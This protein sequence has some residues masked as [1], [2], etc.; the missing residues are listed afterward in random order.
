MRRHLLALT[1][2]TFLAALLAACGG[3]TSAP[4]EGPPAE[5]PGTGYQVEEK[6][7]AVLQQDMAAGRVSSERLVNIYLQRIHDL[8]ANGP[9]LHAVLSVNPVA[10]AEAKRLD[11]ERRDGH[12]RGPLHGIPTLLKDNIESR[13]PIATTAGSLALKDN[14]TGRD[15]VIVGRLREAGAVILGKTNLSEWANFR[16]THSTSG[17]SGVGGLTRNP[18][19]LDRN[20]CGSSSGSAAA[21]AANLAAVAVGTETDGSIT[22]PA[23]MNGIVGLK[24]TVGLM[25]RTHIVPISA[26]Q[27]TAGPMTRTVTDAAALL[28]VMAGGDPEDPA[29]RQAD[30]RKRDYT[31]GLSAESLLGKRLGVMKFL[32]GY[33]PS[34]DAVFKQATAQL[35]AAGATLIEIPAFDGLDQLGKDEF[36]LMTADFRTGING[37]LVTTAS[38]VTVRSLKDLIAFNVANKEREMPFFAQEL[39]EA[40]EATSTADAKA[41]DRTRE[42]VRKAAG[43]NGIDRLLREHQLDALIAPSVHP[44]YPTDLVNGD[45]ILG[46]APQLPAIAGYPHLTVPMGEVQGLPVGISFVGRAWSE[47]ELLSM[48]YAFEQRVAARRVPTYATTIAPH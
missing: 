43:P 40:A 38:A 30:A 31:A 20:A 6:T 19:A 21:I 39:L 12:V 11:Q 3:N 9:A 45:H 8:D 36:A 37:Y 16:S 1:S 2:A 48:G 24:P 7:I 26:T 28:T 32:T 22:M 4:A 29:T 25:S 41:T 46:G 23:A 17:W 44:A 42:R 18:Y 33:L 13:D 10:V 14:V 47:G 15:A 27:D 5:T 35:E 34:L